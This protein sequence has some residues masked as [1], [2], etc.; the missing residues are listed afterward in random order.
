MSERTNADRVEDARN[1]LV[2]YAQGDGEDVRDLIAD[3]MHLCDA[4][5]LDPETEIQSARSHYYTE[6]GCYSSEGRDPNG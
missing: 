3:L 1:A 4:D 2:G 6:K 5:G